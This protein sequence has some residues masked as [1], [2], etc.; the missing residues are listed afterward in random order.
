MLYDDLN[1]DIRFAMHLHRIYIMIILCALPQ[2]LSQPYAIHFAH[3]AVN[4]CGKLY[5]PQNTHIQTYDPSDIFGI[6]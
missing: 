4:L 2:S 1:V 3:I 5:H 6:N